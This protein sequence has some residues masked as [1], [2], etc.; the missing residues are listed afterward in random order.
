MM[1]VTCVDIP[2][3]MRFSSRPVATVQ[4]TVLD[5]LGPERVTLLT[6][7]LRDLLS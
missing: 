2:V 6:H 4:R 7:L 5:Q 1:T 3:S